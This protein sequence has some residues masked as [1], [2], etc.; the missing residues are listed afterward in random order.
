MRSSL[1]IKGKKI[2]STPSP[3]SGRGLGSKLLNEWLNTYR[4]DHLGDGG[5]RTRPKWY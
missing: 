4:N 5:G 2:S 1:P 3:H